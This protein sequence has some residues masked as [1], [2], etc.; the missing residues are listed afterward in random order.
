MKLIEFREN[1]IDIV[2]EIQRA[3][4]K[5][6]YDKYHDDDTNPYMEKRK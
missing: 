2:F 4:Y 5:P 3:A 6:L 1:D